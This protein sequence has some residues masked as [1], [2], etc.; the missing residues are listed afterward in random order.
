MI[1]TLIDTDYLFFLPLVNATFDTLPFSFPLSLSFR[2][3]V[4][5]KLAVRVLTL[6]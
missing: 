5:F 3:W 6:N 2:T 1:M 4:L